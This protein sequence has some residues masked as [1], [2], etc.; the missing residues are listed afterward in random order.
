MGRAHKF[1]LQHASPYDP[2]YGSAGGGG[3]PCFYSSGEDG[4]VCFFDLRVSDSQALGRMAATVMGWQD[5]GGGSS[6]AGPSPRRRTRQIIDLNAIHVNPARPW[7]LVVGG[8]DEVTYLRRT[9]TMTC[10][11]SDLQELRAA[12]EAA[13]DREA[14]GTATRKVAP[15]TTN[16]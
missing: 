1:A 4:D 9:T 14:M 7:Q 15:G 8:A 12:A 5:G 10:I 2:A 6:S 3:P 11:F 16:P 13:G